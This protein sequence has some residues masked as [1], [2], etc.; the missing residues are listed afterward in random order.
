MLSAVVG[1]SG[2][3]AGC[4]GGL[5]TLDVQ[6]AGPKGLVQPGQPQTF[7]V[8]VTNQGPNDAAGVTARV[9]LPNGFHYKDTTS[10]DTS[11]VRTQPIDAEVN[12][13]SPLWGIWLLPGPS[14]QASG[15]KV[16]ITFELVADAAPT[17]YSL[18]ARASGDTTSGDSRSKPLA[19]QLDAAPKLSM[20]VT[21]S[22]TAVQPGGQLTY[23]VS[24]TNDGTGVAKGVAV[25]ATL[26]PVF[27]FD[28]SNK[29]FKGN[30][31]R[32]G[33]TDPAKGA[34]L[35]YYDGFDIPA[36][37]D[38]GPGLLDL[39]F[40]VDALKS[41]GA[42]GIYTVGVQLTAGNAVRLNLDSST[43]VQVSP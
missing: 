18:V 24:I 19:V 12:S 8:T 9:D 3:G 6:L 43:P 25:L 21:A 26:P 22:P 37:S 15:G 40:R 14:G 1:L 41:A 29:P 4:G 16:I 10:I 39:S 20:T 2:V 28:T 33:G 17:T 11:S 5:T 34:L 42:P 23:T 13:A 36:R 30:Y 35:V 32:N 31:S 27:A 38:S 7:K